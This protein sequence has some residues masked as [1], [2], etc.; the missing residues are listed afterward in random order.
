MKRWRQWLGENRWTAS[1]LF[2]VAV[3]YSFLMFAS[4]FAPHEDK[5]TAPAK[6]EA[7][8]SLT[9][10]EIKQKEEIVRQKLMQRPGLMNL[11]SLGVFGI[12]LWGILLDMLLIHWRRTK[13]PWLTGPLPRAPVCWGLKDVFQ[14]LV[15]LF[16]VEG[17]LF[18]F[19]LF[20]YWLTGLEF[21]AD[22]LL[23]TNSLIRDVCVAVFVLPELA[24]FKLHA[25]SIGCDA[26]MPCAG[27]GRPY[28]LGG[29]ANPQ[30]ATRTPWTP[31]VA[32]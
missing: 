22:A 5:K 8:R 9:S 23:L 31:S 27:L 14:A 13:R 3:L 30:E 25:H 29:Q 21:S 10:E 12:F 7:G 17:C 19:Q 2:F 32:S 15:L 24:G 18:L 28:S 4:V 11:I 20:G 6:T 1:M 26:L 16:F